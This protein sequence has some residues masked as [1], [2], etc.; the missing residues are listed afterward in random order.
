MEYRLLRSLYH[1]MGSHDYMAEFERRKNSH[2]T[3]T[4]PINIRDH[5]TETESQAFL[6]CDWEMLSLI[7]SIAVHVQAITEAFI[8]LPN[9][10][11]FYYIR[12]CLIDEIQTTNDI[13]GIFS[14]RMEVNETIQSVDDNYAGK[15]KRFIGMVRKYDLLIKGEHEVPL[16]TNADI[17]ALYDDIVKDEIPADRHPDGLLYRK[18][19]VAVVSKTGQIRHKGVFGEDAIIQAMEHSLSILHNDQIPMLVRIPLFHY[20]F[21]YVH[22]FY[23]GNGRTNRFISSYLLYDFSPLIGLSLS[24]ILKENK[25][26][27]YKS[28]QICNDA[29]NAGDVTPFVLSFLSFIDS[30]A[31]SVIT[32]LNDGLLK[33]NFYNDGIARIKFSNEDKPNKV[34]DKKEILWYFIQNALF[35]DEGF[36]LEELMRYSKR[37][38]T[39]VSKLVHS[40]IEDNGIPLQISENKPKIYKIDLDAFD[41]YLASQV[42]PDN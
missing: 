24:R 32:Q 5:K 40:L 14:T 23:D 39:T 41:E 1:V 15:K 31:E 28:F 16:N 29:K 2:Q 8:M 11:K 7:E 4:F 36:T 35:F 20:F 6:V 18:G 12:K 42:S 3:L 30:A 22:P 21:G 33:L 17:R 37:S 19:S 10:A 25:S 9:A 13:E 38:R 34:K 27:Y 26:A